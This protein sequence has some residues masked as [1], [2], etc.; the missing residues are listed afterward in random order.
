LFAAGSIPAGAD[1]LAEDQRWDTHGNVSRATADEAGSYAEAARLQA[2]QNFS[3][4]EWTSLPDGFLTSNLQTLF[5][6]PGA[7]RLLAE[8]QLPQLRALATQRGV[9]LSPAAPAGIAADTLP[10]GPLQT[11][12]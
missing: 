2:Q 10:W 1:D 4:A 9:A 5:S 7:R 8:G 11:T 3:L 6:N 12:G